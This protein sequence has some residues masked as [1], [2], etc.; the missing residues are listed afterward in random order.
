M[1]SPLL[2]ALRARLGDA[3]TQSFRL[4]N[5]TAA[6]AWVTKYN[7]SLSARIDGYIALGD[8][9]AWEYPWP[10]V[11]IFDGLA[12]GDARARFTALA[13]TTLAH[14]G[15]E[16]AIFTY[17]MGTR[18]ADRARRGALPRATSLPAPAIVDGELRF[19]PYPLPAGFDLRDRDRV[20]ARAVRPLAGSRVRMRAPPRR[21]AASVRAR[22]GPPLARSHCEAFL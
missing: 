5:A 17:Q 8:A 4:A 15:R 6:H 2:A 14:F 11:V 13:A 22:A 3:A 19:R 7:R 21:E 20:G 18:A 12:L 9:C 10:T 16:Q 1:Q